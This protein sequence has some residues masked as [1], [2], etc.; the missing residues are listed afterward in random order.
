MFSIQQLGHFSFN[1]MYINASLLITILSVEHK[2]GLLTPY[3]VTFRVVTQTTDREN[4]R[5]RFAVTTRNFFLDPASLFNPST[6]A[7]VQNLCAY[8]PGL[9]PSLSPSPLHR[10]FVAKGGSFQAL[11][12]GG[13]GRSPDGFSP[14]LDVGAGRCHASDRPTG[15]LRCRRLSFSIYTMTSPRC[16]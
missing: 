14:A 15:L 4:K 9:L 13:G 8:R 12:K 7:H 2:R 3:Q 1:E 16:I 5:Q 6:H 10:R 11:R